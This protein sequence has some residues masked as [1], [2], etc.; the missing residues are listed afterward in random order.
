LTFASI[1]AP[2]NT[3]ERYS[4][5]RNGKIGGIAGTVNAR[6]PAANIFI[7]AVGLKSSPFGGITGSK[8]Y[9]SVTNK[10]ADGVLYFFFN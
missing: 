3:A 8:I 2:F 10:D 6:Q 9:Q 7:P 1:A 4:S 5:V